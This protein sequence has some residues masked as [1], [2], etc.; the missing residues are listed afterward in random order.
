[1]IEWLHF[2]LV[3]FAMLIAMALVSNS[4]MRKEA[5]PGFLVVLNISAVIAILVLLIRSESASQNEIIFQVAVSAVLCGAISIFFMS[6]AR[7]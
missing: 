2:L 3:P 6:N 7:K 4:S 1:M 5:K